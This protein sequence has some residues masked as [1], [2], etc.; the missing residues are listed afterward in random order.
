MYTLPLALRPLSGFQH[1]KSGEKD[2]KRQLKS[3][4]EK[5]ENTA[6]M[7]AWFELKYCCT[8]LTVL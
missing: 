8:S 5:A 2:K 3:T 4:S 1:N 7:C 6:S